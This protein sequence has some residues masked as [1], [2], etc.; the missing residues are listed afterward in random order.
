LTA[1]ILA[2]EIILRSGQHH[3]D[4]VECL[5]MVLVFDARDEAARQRPVKVAL[6]LLTAA[7]GA[8]AT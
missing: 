5:P 3:G 6:C 2:F 4:L 7:A 1:A 8:I